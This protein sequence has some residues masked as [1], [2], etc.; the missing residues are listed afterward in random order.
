MHGPLSLA[1]S[2][3]MLGLQLVYLEVHAISMGVF[4]TRR[5]VQIY[6]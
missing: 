4:C 3:Q 5:D 6:T 1:M 2:F